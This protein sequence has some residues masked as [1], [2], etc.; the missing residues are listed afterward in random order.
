MRHLTSD[1]YAIVF[2]AASN[3]RTSIH[4]QDPYSYLPYE[5]QLVG[6]TTMLTGTCPPEAVTEK[7]VALAKTFLYDDH[8][9]DINKIIEA[10][11]GPFEYDFVPPTQSETV[12]LAQQMTEQMQL[13][14]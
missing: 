4:E 5:Q 14:Q 6:Y 1:Q 8:R 3:L 9:E 10:F 2:L 12:A 13:T 7:A 11:I